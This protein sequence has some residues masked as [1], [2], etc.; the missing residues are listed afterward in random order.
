[1]SVLQR[2]ET[3]I[4]PVAFGGRTITMVA[5]TTA[6][7]VGGDER[8]ALRVR[9]RPVHVEVLDENGQ[10]HVVQ[11][12]DFEQT[13]ITA[14]AIGGVASACALRGI[15]WSLNRKSLNRKGRS[16]P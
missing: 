1:M 9:S 10:R 3:T 16:T 11:V 12:R 6:I 15:R 4:G 8:G 14:I 2:G 7:H 13:I 5:R